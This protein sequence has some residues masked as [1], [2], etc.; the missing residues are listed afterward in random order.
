MIKNGNYHKEML[1]VLSDTAS[2]MIN[3]LLLVDP[4]QRMSVTEA[5]S[6]PWIQDYGR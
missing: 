4:K 3:G 5:L 1:R 6:H 2:E